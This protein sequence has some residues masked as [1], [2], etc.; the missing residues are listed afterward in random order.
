VLPYLINDGAD[1]PTPDYSNP[2]MIQLPEINERSRKEISFDK[3]G[4]SDGRAPFPE[5]KK[6]V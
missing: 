5:Y 1:K 4:L 6:S 2:Y 3:I